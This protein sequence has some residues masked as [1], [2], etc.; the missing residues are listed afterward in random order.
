V[1]NRFL[2]RSGP[3]FYPPS[4]WVT[5]VDN[6][7][8]LWTAE[9]C[10][11]PIH[12]A[13]RL[14]PS[15]VPRNTRVLPSPTHLLGVTAFTRSWDRSC[16]VAEQW[17]SMWRSGPKLCTTQ[18]MLWASGG[19][20]LIPG[21]GL[22]DSSTVCG[23]GL[24][25]FP[26]P[27]ELGRRPLSRLACGDESGQLR[28]PQGVDGGPATFLWRNGS[29]VGVIEQPETASAPGAG[30]PGHSWA[31]VGAVEDARGRSWGAVE[32]APAVSS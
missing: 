11:H 18:G 8:L 14:V 3:V 32:D 2:R 7:G 30:L 4:L 16:F 21:A 6:Q 19:Q 25:T 12:R 13:T 1:D 27:A 17:T 5:A 9:S 26:H 24:P 23:Y 22:P 15:S 28:C 20:L 10:A 29:P 31:V